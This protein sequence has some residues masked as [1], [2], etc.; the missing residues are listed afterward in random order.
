MK[1][2]ATILYPFNGQSG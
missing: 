1:T 2:T